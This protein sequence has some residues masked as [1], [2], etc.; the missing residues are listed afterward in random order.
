MNREISIPRIKLRA[1]ELR[2][3]IV[4]MDFNSSNG[5]V[6]G[7]LSSADIFATLFSGSSTTALK[8]QLQGIL[9]ATALYSV[10]GI[11]ATHIT[12]F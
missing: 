2:R 6:G 3:R 12:Q 4:D 10:K 7:A 5:H 9:S 1:A 8:S 11:S